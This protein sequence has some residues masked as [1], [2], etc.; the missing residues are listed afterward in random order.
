[1]CHRFLGLVICTVDITL[2]F[3]VLCLGSF[4]IFK[5]QNLLLGEYFFTLVVMS[6]HLFA[7]PLSHSVAS[8]VGF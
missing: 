4:P 7:L 6:G 2:G 8:V 1:M 5:R 3:G